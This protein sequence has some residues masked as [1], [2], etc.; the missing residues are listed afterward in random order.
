[1]G[2]KKILIIEDEKDI[3]TVL[4]LAL[5]SNG[6]KVSEAYD[7]LSAID[8]IEKE[9]YDLIVLDIMIPKFDGNSVNMRLK[10]SPQTADIPVIIMTGKD[11]AK[12]QA[13]RIIDELKINAYLEKPFSVSLIVNKIKEILKNK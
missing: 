1:M 3:V 7:G 2:L 10:S 6:F 8:M 13:D 12:N 9:K 5:E 11:I 4:K